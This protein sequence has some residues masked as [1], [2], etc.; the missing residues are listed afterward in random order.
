MAS[1]WCTLRPSVRSL[2]AM[3]S[4]GFCQTKILW[5]IWLTALVGVAVATTDKP[6]RSHLAVI[7]MSIGSVRRDLYTFLLACLLVLLFLPP[8][9]LPAL[10]FPSHSCWPSRILVCCIY[11]LCVLFVFLS[12]H[13]CQLCFYSY[14]L[15]LMI[16]TTGQS[17]MASTINPSLPL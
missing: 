3:S 10:F 8:Q 5:L 4:A 15:S 9:R 7:S 13:H 2:I 11:C 6:G 12:L 14:F 16:P 17:I 1:N